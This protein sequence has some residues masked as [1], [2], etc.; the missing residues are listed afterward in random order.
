MKI[1]GLFLCFI[2][3]IS[4]SSQAAINKLTWDYTPP[5][6]KVDRL[7]SES[8]LSIFWWNI[9]CGVLNRKLQDKYKENESL[10]SNI[11]NISETES[12]PDLI[13]LGEHCPGIMPSTILRRIKKNYRHDYHLVKN[14]PYTRT[15]NGIIVFSKLKIQAVNKKNLELGPTPQDTTRT[16]LLLKV[17]H[18]DGDFY[19]S[20]LHFYN[21]WGH[22][23][24][25]DLVTKATGT[26]NPNYEQGSLFLDFLEEDLNL[27]EDPYIAIGDFNS[28]GH[29]FGFI[30]MATYGLFKS[31]LR[32]VGTGDATY[33]TQAAKDLGSNYPD[34]T[35]D[36]VFTND[37]EGSHTTLLPL[38]GSDHYPLLWQW[39]R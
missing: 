18:E 7:T 22:L 17:S 5:S 27:N 1:L 30:D 6:W 15:R 20:P 3:L 32:D 13:I 35:I 19:L 4:P 11:A 38:R 23:S 12:S 2:L 39:N 36:H 29:V 28:A 37:F 25:L 33:P 10:Y 16:Y 34:L 31:K 26:D 21:P 8:S 9:G 24:G 14:N